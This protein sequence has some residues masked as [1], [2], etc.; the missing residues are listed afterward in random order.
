MTVV[1]QK[2]GYAIRADLYEGMTQLAKDNGQTATHI[3]DEAVEHYL[4]F[5]APTQGTVRPEIM[6]M[7]RKSIEK[8][9]KLLEL[10]AK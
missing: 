8:N 1:R 6:A 2:I 9:R 5:V 4:R 3:L 7:A 10:L